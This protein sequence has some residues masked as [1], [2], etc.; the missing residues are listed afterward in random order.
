MSTTESFSTTEECTTQSVV[1]MYLYVDIC[2]MKFDIMTYET[3]ITKGVNQNM[4]FSQV[5]HHAMGG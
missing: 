4:F 2:N 1:C 3:R 5:P